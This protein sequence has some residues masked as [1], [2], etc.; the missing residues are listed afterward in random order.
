LLVILST[1]NA[2]I[3]DI[4]GNDAVLIT[5]VAICLSQTAPRFVCYYRKTIDPRS[6][7][8]L[9]TA[10]RPFPKHAM[11][12]LAQSEVKRLQI[13]DDYGSAEKRKVHRLPARFS[14][15]Y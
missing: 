2:D 11:F 9:V 6:A 1:N 13:P 3:A 15:G 12:V 14:A 5:C 7:F 4:A 10:F 8:V